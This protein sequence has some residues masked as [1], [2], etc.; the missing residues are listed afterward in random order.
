M[1]LAQG[2]L[3]ETRLTLY[4]APKGGGVVTSIVLSNY[5]SGT[6]TMGT[7]VNLY[8]KRSGKEP[9]LIPSIPLNTDVNVGD[10]YTDDTLRTLAEGD[11]IQG[12]ALDEGVVGFIIH[13]RDAGTRP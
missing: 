1:P 11:E 3:S 4:R 7:T 10:C 8:E 5:T 9:S 12:S 2:T 13:G 6:G